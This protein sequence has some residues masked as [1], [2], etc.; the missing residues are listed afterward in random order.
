M[1]TIK[2]YL[3]T[4]VL[5]IGSVEDYVKRLVKAGNGNDAQ[6]SAIE[7]QLHDTDCEIIDY[8]VIDCEYLIRVK[9]VIEITDYDEIKILTKYL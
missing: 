2:T 4:L 5:S 8:E 1:Q 6:I 7:D 3:V 9:S